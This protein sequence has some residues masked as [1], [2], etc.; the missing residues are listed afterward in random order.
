MYSV[1]L[2]SSKIQFGKRNADQNHNF[3]LWVRWLLLRVNSSYCTITVTVPCIWL[4]Y[5]GTSHTVMDIRSDTLIAEKWIVHMN[6]GYIITK[7]TVKDRP[8]SC[9]P[10]LSDTQPMER[11][12]G[13]MDSRHLPKIFKHLAKKIRWYSNLLLHFISD[14]KIVL[15]KLQAPVISMYIEN[16]K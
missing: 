16:Y 14:K 5:V 4:G 6:N 3:Y 12:E 10:Q 11:E 2:F 8:Q 7:A 15:H 9:Y 13:S 1:S